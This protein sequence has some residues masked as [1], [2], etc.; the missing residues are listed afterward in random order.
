[1]RFNTFY[2]KKYL[3]NQMNANKK[4]RKQRKLRK[5]GN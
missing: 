1:M 3:E 4:V 5:T 2:V